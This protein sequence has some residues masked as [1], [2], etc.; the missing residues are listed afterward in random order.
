MMRLRILRLRR[1]YGIT[2]DHAAI[3]AALIWGHDG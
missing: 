2:D 1:L 3:L